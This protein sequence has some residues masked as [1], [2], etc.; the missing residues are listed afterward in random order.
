MKGKG[1]I[2]AGEG[3]LQRQPLFSPIPPNQWLLG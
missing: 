2:A 1:I 3:S